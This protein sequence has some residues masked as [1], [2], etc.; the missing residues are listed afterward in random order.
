MYYIEY[1][2]LGRA[3]GSVF[4][5]SGGI[6]IERGSRHEVVNNG[7]LPPAWHSVAQV[8]KVTS[9]DTIKVNIELSQPDTVV[10]LESDVFN[11]NN[12][13]LSRKLWRDG[14]NA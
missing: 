14:M 6:R 12:M 3:I 5:R 4:A 10:I 11:P 9:D 13:Y 8:Y 1:T 7:T 2:G